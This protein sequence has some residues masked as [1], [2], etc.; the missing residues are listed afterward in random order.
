MVFFFDG[1][2][3]GLH[4]KITEISFQK[5]RAEYSKEKEKLLQ[6]IDLESQAKLDLERKILDKDRIL[7]E[8]DEK[9]FSLDKV[10]I[11]FHMIEKK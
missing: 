11:S 4:D 3:S 6:K 10:G 1:R 9:L 7:Q 2:L 8:K 5:L